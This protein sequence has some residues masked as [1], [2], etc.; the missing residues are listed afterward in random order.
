MTDAFGTKP[1]AVAWFGQFFVPLSGVVGGDATALLLSV[2]VCQ[3]GVVAFVIAACRKIGLSYYATAVGTL[4]VAAS[5][6]FVL[7]GHSYFA[8]PIQTLA[9]AWGLYVLASAARWPIALTAVQIPGVV[10]F[11]MLAKLSSPA[12]IGLP[13]AAAVLL[14]IRGP[15]GGRPRR[16]RSSWRDWRVITSGITTVALVEGAIGWYDVNLHSAIAFARQSS[17]NT[18]LYGFNRGFVTELRMWMRNFRDVSFLPRV[19]VAMAFVLVAAIAL[20]VRRRGLRPSLDPLLIVS[21]ACVGTIAL[22]I[23]LFATQAN[24]ET[25]YLLGLIP[26]LGLVV[27]IVVDASRSRALALVALAALAGEFGLV[28]LQSFGYTAIASMSFPTLAGPAAETSFARELNTIVGETCN[29][30]SAG[31]INIVG[32]DYP[33]FNHNTRLRCWPPSDTRRVV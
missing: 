20:L 33:W 15:A 6:L 4:V 8:D 25:R 10:A 19:D 2:A 9:I 32:A 3:I 21:I 5:P 27:A 29:S 16:T 28:Q 12:Y 31:R 17:A 14:A 24:S 30:A 1:P 26:C 7:L 22:V 18:G 13:L 23:V 11:A